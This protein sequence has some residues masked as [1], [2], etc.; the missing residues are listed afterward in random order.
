MAFGLRMSFA[1]LLCF[2][3]DFDFLLLA[4]L[5]RLILFLFFGSGFDLRLTFCFKLAFAFE[6]GLF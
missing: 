5:S 3:V 1:L 4:S 6:L 2:F